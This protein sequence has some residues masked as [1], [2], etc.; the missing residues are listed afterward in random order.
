MPSENLAAYQRL[1]AEYF[2]D[3]QPKGPIERQ[4]VQTLADTAWRMNRIAILENNMFAF[5]PQD[6]NRNADPEIRSSLSMLPALSDHN[7]DLATLSLHEQR[8][9]RLYER[10]LKQLTAVQAARREREKADIEQ[11]AN[12]RKLHEMKDLP[13]EPAEDGFVF[14]NSEIDQYIRRADR[15]KE[16]NQAAFYGSV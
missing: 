11:A 4:F 9:S 3:L 7:R 8:L 2:D 16:A 14:S 12:L 5:Q 13:Y 10:T 6:D 15:A 1:A